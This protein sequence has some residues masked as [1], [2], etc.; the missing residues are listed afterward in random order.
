M[1]N[2]ILKQMNIVRVFRKDAFL[3]VDDE[4]LQVVACVIADSKDDALRIYTETQ[5]DESDDDRY[6]VWEIDLL[7]QV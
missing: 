4:R 2:S 3:I 5:T 7:Q 6:R 1:S